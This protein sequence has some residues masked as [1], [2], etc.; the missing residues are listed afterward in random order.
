MS[1][2]RFTSLCVLGAV[3][4]FV[5]VSCSERSLVVMDV[6][7]SDG[8]VAF[9]GVTLL[10]RA[11]R[12]QQ[13]RFDGVHFDSSKAYRAGVYLSSDVSGTITLTAEVD[14]PVQNCKVG[15]G[16][17]TASNVS[18]GN[19]VQGLTLI[20]HPL[21]PCVPIADGGMPGDGGSPGTGGMTGGATGGAPASGGNQ[22]AGG[23]NATGGR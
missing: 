4:A 7:S 11:G 15:T 17:V 13:T 9:A 8:S 14:D 5:I 1:M 21:Q 23:S 16:S 18:P 12:E 20:I 19:T 2:K 3:A 22:G 10:V 6:K